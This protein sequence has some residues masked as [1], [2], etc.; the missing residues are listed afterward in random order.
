M[1]TVSFSYSSRLFLS[2]RSS[3]SSQSGFTL[4]ELMIVV[5]I[6]GILSAIAIPSYYSYIIKGQSNA[7]LSE[8]KSYSNDVLYIL[9]D[10]DDSTIPSSPTVKACMSITD[11]TGWTLDTQQ[12]II[13]NAKPPLNARIEC[14]IPNGSPCRI[15]P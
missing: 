6:I 2:W 1:S 12:K 4:I 14:D 7:C 15:M 8:A 3:Y 10:Q 13:A 5:V 11:A 9:N